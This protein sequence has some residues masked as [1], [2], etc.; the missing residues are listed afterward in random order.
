MGGGNIPGPF[1]TRLV[2]LDRKSDR[3][4]QGYATDMASTSQRMVHTLIDK[5]TFSLRVS[6]VAHN[7]CWKISR[8]TAR[9]AASERRRTIKY[10]RNLPWA[11]TFLW[12]PKPTDPN[13]KRILRDLQRS[14][15]PPVI[16]S[17]ITKVL[18]CPE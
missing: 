12:L 5:R 10:I 14:W 11:N 3:E 9:D 18:K 15:P 16:V 13:F 17:H 2:T 7:H 6:E 1:H 8:R 4:A